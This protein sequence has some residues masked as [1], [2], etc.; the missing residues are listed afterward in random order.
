MDSRD[1]IRVVVSYSHQDLI[2]FDKYT[3]IPYLQRNLIKDGVELWY[4]RRIGVGE[5]WRQRILGKIDDADIAILLVSEDYLNSEFVAQVELPRIEIRAMRNELF[6]CPILVARCDWKSVDLLRQRQFLPGGNPLITYVANEAAWDQVQHEILMEMRRLIGQVHSARKLRSSEIVVVDTPTHEG[7]EA[8]HVSAQTTIPRVANQHAGERKGLNRRLALG[9]FAVALLASIGALVFPWDSV[10]VE[11]R[12]R[13]RNAFFSALPWLNWVI[14]DPTEYNPYTNQ[15]PSEASIRAD[16]R[17]L[18]SHGL[19]GLITTS[20]QNTLKEIPRIAHEEGIQMVIAGVWD[21]RNPNEVAAALGI[22]EHAD[23]FCLGHSGLQKRYSMRELE[24]LVGR[25]GRE[26]G[27][28]VAVS[29]LVGDYETNPTLVELGDILFPDAH[30]QWHEGQTAE[31]AW[32]ETVATARKLALLAA[33]EPDRPVILKMVSYP[34]S[35][36]SSLTPEA[37]LAFYHQAVEGVRNRTDIP[38]RVKF[39][40]L[41]A[42]DTPWKTVDNGW[43]LSEQYTGLFTFDRSPKPAVTHVRWST[44]R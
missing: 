42:F 4:D 19:N 30:G 40:F 25:F 6:I 33:D 35:G 22:A 43:A 13:E 18:R 7:R 29:E 2:W 16:L 15:F 37:Q 28:P 24:A 11:E 8:P 44:G 1:S 34:S 14:Y 39:A 5:D 27:R 9:T 20:V 17:V 31:A 32:Q 23:A 21:P 36:A 10:R 38:A 26:T 12:A 41:G 3:L